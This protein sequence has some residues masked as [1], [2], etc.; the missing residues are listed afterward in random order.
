MGEHSK[1]ALTD[2][3]TRNGNVL[4]Q[5]V[6]ESDRK[7]WSGQRPISVMQWVGLLVMLLAAGV[8]AVLGAAATGF[9]YRA[10]IVVF[11]GLVLFVVL[12]NLWIRRKTLQREKH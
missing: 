5:S 7:F 12:G 10:F 1:N 4:R 11:A 9:G 2:V 8:V 3:E 6:V